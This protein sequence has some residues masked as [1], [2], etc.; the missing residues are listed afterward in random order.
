MED[1]ARTAKAIAKV[2][3][4]EKLTTVLFRINYHIY[5]FTLSLNM[6]M[7]MDLEVFLKCFLTE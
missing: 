6:L 3:N 2:L 4:P 7:D 5:I 1:V